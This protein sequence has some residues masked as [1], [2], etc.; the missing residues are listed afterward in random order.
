MGTCATRYCC[1]LKLR[2]PFPFWLPCGMVCPGNTST[3]RP[4]RWAAMRQALSRAIGFTNAA[5]EGRHGYPDGTE[6]ATR[7]RTA[8][9]SFR[10][11]PA[12]GRIGEILSW[13]SK[14]AEWRAVL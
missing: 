5:R 9:L 6:L 13:R 1:C 2:R 11:N 10:G 3:Y 12:R 4:T 8:E 14:R 7:Y